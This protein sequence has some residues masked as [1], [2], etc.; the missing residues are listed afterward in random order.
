[1]STLILFIFLIHTPDTN[2]PKTIVTV[3]LGR[4]IIPLL[5]RV[6]SDGSIYVLDPYMGTIFHYDR[7]GALARTFGSKG[8]GPGEMERPRSLFLSDQRLFVTGDGFVNAFTREGKF[9]EK[10]RMPLPGK[11]AKVIDG[12]VLRTSQIPPL[13]DGGKILWYDNA[14]IHSVLLAQ[15]GTD[16]SANFELLFKKNLE[17]RS[18]KLAGEYAMLAIG[19]DGKFA[20][21][22]PPGRFE[23]QVIDI[24][25]KAVVKTISKDIQPVVFDE[26][27]SASFLKEVNAGLAKYGL[28]KKG[29]K[30]LPDAYPLVSKI[31]IG[32]DGILIIS[33][34]DPRNT[35]RF[36]HWFFDQAGNEAEPILSPESSLRVLAIFDRGVYVTSYSKKT[37]ESQILV[38]ALDN[39]NQFVKENPLY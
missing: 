24:H 6:S 32:M 14:F 5:A 11:W 38:C 19:P 3:D 27:E 21:F 31:W 39:V 37:E 13:Q 28:P 4:P 8:Q 34:V 22:R 10:I 16:N 1:M 26:K 2:G 29:K 12:W 23:I 25:Q 15:W 33:S 30:D 35:S 18:R 36:R 9:I 7:N 17:N 20:Y